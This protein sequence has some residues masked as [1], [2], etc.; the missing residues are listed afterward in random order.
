MRIVDDSGKELPM[1]GKAAGE[2]QVRGPIIMSSYFNVS[3]LHSLQC[4]A[5]GHFP[6][7]VSTKPKQPADL[8]SYRCASVSASHDCKA[9]DSFSCVGG[10]GLGAVYRVQR[11]DLSCLQLLR[12]NTPVS[13]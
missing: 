5:C 13:V 11:A 12:M 2:V 9:L 10:A 8:D 1:D 4:C 3:A 6:F 7:G